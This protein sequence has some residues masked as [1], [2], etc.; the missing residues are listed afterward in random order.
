MTTQNTVKVLPTD[1]VNSL[2]SKHGGHFAYAEFIKK[3][4]TIRKINFKIC[5]K[6]APNL[7]NYPNMWTIAENGTVARTLNSET[8]VKISI[9]KLKLVAE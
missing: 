8:V 7:A 6:K 1:Y 2:L 9:N 4:G 5:E 3:D